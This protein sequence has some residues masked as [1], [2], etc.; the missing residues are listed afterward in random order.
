MLACGVGVWWWWVTDE[1][2]ADRRVRRKR[3]G[4]TGETRRLKDGKDW[5]LDG[6]WRRDRR[7][8]AGCRL[9]WAGL[10]AIAGWDWD[11]DCLEGDPE[12]PEW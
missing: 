3:Q 6:D 10:G 4:L 12:C 11:W 1:V 2:V 9:G 7:L 8:A 5:R